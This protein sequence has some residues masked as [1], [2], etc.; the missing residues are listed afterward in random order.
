MWRCL[1]GCQSYF[2]LPG[3]KSVNVKQLYLNG[4]AKYQSVIY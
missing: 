2:G 4:V 3:V 1:A